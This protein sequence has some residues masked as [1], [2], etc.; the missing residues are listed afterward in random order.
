MFLI[1][2]HPQSHALMPD[3][4]F[5]SLCVCEYNALAL[6]Y[7]RVSFSSF[8]IVFFSSFEDSLGQPFG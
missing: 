3:P 4:A 5:V 8:F 7:L 6:D 2:P 1:P